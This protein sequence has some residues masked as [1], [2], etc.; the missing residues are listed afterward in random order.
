MRGA[1]AILTPA[2]LSAL[3]TGCGDDAEMLAFVAVGAFAGL[4]H[5]EIQRLDWSEVRLEDRFIEVK[6]GN[7]KTAS[8]RLVPITDN[9]RKWLVPHWK[10]TGPVCPYASM[11]KQLL[12]LAEAVNEAWQKETP[13]GHSPM[14]LPD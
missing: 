4:R 8:R 2:E 10:P 1:P 9:L 7:A 5:A 11:S 12:W 13:P 3:L 14:V 6:A